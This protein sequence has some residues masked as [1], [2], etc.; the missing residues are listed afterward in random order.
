MSALL[1]EYIG[2]MI[3]I[4]LGN[5]VVAGVVLSKSKSQNG[6][7][8]V[9]AFG[10]GFAVTLAVYVSTRFSGGHLNPAVSLA[11]LMQGGMSFNMFIGYVICQVLGALT[12]SCLMYCHYYPHWKVSDDPD[13]KLAIFCTGPAIKHTFSNLMSEVI[14]TFAFVLGVLSLGVTELANG[15]G[16]FIVGMLVVSIGLSLGGTTGY[17]INPARDFGPRLAHFLLPIPGKRDSN[18]SYAWIPIVGPCLGSALA[19]LLF[20]ALPAIG[21]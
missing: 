15:F 4:L 14:A 9:I 11:V 8:I 10:W 16:P 20:M 6:G 21:K 12:G 7:W 17:A 5:G 1:G 18:W 13:G 3:L 2:T 19:V